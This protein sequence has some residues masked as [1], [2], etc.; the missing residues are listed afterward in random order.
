MP[1]SLRCKLSKLRFQDKITQE[2]YKELLEKL[3]GH[4]QFIRDMCELKWIPVEERLPEVGE[5]VLVS[6]RGCKEVF[7]DTYVNNNSIHSRYWDAYVVAW[8]PLPAPYQPAKMQC[9]ED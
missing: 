1:N 2:E 6:E 7:I 5:T 9:E 3:D 4:D 8:M